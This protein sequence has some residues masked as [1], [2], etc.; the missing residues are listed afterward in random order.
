MLQKWL[1]KIDLDEDR[2][3]GTVVERPSENGPFAVFVPS[4]GGK[5]TVCTARLAERDH[6]LATIVSARPLAKG[7]FVWLEGDA[8]D[9]GHVVEQCRSESDEFRIVLRR[10]IERRRSA[11]ELVRIEAE[12]W[13]LEGAATRRARATII[14]L[15]RQG[16]RL[17]LAESGP[18]RGRA[19]LHFRDRECACEVRYR[20]QS[21]D[22]VFV[23]VEF[24]AAE[25]G[26]AGRLRETA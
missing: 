19:T 23:G 14:N 5:R 11:R 22:A 20:T 16:A 2:G 26:A 7:Q 1:A 6:D 3:D 21:A 18:E 8:P 10:R 17:E 15:S 13:W 24:A 9:G 12:L 25:E 4:W